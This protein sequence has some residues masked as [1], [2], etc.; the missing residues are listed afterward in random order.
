MRFLRLL[1]VVSILSI[2]TVGLFKLTEYMDP[3]FTEYA[4]G[5]VVGAAIATLFYLKACHKVIVDLL[6]V[7]FLE[8]NTG[9]TAIRGQPKIRGST[10]S[11]Q[12]LPVSPAKVSNFKENVKSHYYYS[13]KERI[14]DYSNISFYIPSDPVRSGLVLNGRPPERNWLSSLSDED[15]YQWLRFL[16]FEENHTFVRLALNELKQRAK[17]GRIAPHYNYYTA[18][19][20]PVVAVDAIVV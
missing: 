17:R 10:S 14:P 19:Q 7:I 20:R 2:L 18:K 8:D 4:T 12:F 11:T 6:K 13:E 5:A 3:G 1:I 9:G 16:R 15:V